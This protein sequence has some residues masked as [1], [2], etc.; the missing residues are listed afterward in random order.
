MNSFCYC[1]QEYYGRHCEHRVQHR[2]CGTI[3]HGT[4]IT[5]ACNVCHC[6]DGRMTCKA[7]KFPNCGETFQEGFETAPDYHGGIEKQFEDYDLFYDEYE[8][9]SRAAAAK[10]QIL[11]KIILVFYGY[12]YACYMF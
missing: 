7:V 1:K 9:N 4:W 5:A 3:A 8:G 6:F 2:S 10:S 12:L 11:L